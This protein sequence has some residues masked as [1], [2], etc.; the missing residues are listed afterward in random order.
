L[1]TSSLLLVSVVRALFAGKLS[2]YRECE[3]ISGIQISLL[4][5]DEGSK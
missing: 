2:S 3:E 1:E 4:A 5:K